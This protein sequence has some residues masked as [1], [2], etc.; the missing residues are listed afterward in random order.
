MGCCQS[1]P[2]VVKPTVI[3]S[4]SKTQ[5]AK[6]T[7]MKLTKNKVKSNARSFAMNKKNM[8]I[9]SEDFWLLK[10]QVKNLQQLIMS[11][12]IG[13]LYGKPQG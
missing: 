10:L 2:T 5:S 11:D 7:A 3:R 1:N 13:S 12:T 6:K 8:G 9:K 4:I